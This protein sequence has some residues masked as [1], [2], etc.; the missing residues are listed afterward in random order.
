MKASAN[1]MGGGACVRV[2]GD[3]IEIER[4]GARLAMLKW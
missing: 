1:E 2:N 4:S 3:G